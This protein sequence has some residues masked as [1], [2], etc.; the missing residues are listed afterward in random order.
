MLGS[1]QPQG[2]TVQGSLEADLP[3][4]D[5]DQLLD[6]LVKE[7]P[8]IKMALAGLQQNSEALGVGRNVGVQGFAEIGV[9]PCITTEFIQRASKAEI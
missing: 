3:Q 5:E 1:P 9:H 7:S 4:L 8:A 6:S 2:G